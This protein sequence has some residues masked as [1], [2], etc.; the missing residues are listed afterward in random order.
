MGCQKEIAAKIVEREGDDLLALKDSYPT[1]CQAVGE[2]FTAV[3]EADVPP[4]NLRRHD[5]IETNRGRE[6]R[7][8]SYSRPAPRTL[9]QFAGWLRLATLAA[10]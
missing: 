9:P 3:L 2:T 7:R 5:A 10:C 8:E 1:L 6:E 4:A